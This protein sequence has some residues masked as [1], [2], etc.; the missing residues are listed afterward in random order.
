M[1]PALLLRC[2]CT[3]VSR[4]GRVG[5]GRGGARLALS[6]C[7]VVCEGVEG[8][9]AGGGSGGRGMARVV[10]RGGGG[11]RGR[12][13]DAVRNASDV[14]VSVMRGGRRVMTLHM[15]VGVAPAAAAS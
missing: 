4:C 14:A 2:P 12:R 9:E 10:R 5:A 7:H 11:R 3:G 1:V 15:V 13:G 6:C 8:G